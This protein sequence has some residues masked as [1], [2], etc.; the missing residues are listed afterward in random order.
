MEQTDVNLDSVSKEQL[1]IYLADKS[2]EVKTAERKLKKVEERYMTIFKENKGLKKAIEQ[3]FTH[4]SNW[5]T[6]EAVGVPADESERLSQFEAIIA[7]LVAKIDGR[8]KELRDKEASLQ[9]QLS[10]EKER[11]SSGMSSEINRLKQQIYS[12]DDQITQLQERL[13]EMET[14]NFDSLLSDLKKISTKKE[15]NIDEKIKESEKTNEILRLKNEIKV[16]KEALSEK[17]IGTHR[18]HS[19]KDTG[20]H[21]HHKN[22]QKNEKGI[23]TDQS[24]LNGFG[25]QSQHL[26]TSQESRENLNANT[27]VAKDSTLKAEDQNLRQYIK[28]L[29]SKYFA[30]ESQGLDNEKM[31]IMNVIFDVLRFNYDE[32]LRVEKVIQKKGKFLGLFKG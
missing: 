10:E 30:Y 4:T 13:A 23:Q 31:L 26:N 16:L 20:H 7:K 25:K 28:D 21:D 8:L 3:F 9:R 19:L 2:K 15:I 24:D 14:S 17:D 12:K 29:L 27:G 11:S 5:M 1:L 18:V 6:A 22:S 32:K